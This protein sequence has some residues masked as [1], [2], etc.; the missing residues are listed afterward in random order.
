MHTH[1]YSFKPSVAQHCC[2]Y[3]KNKRTTGKERVGVLVPNKTVSFEAW[4]GEREGERKEYVGGVVRDVTFH[5]GRQKNY[6][7]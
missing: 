1:C 7:Y 6:R 3:K 4:R 5:G 2:I